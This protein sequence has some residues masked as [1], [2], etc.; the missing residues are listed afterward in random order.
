MQGQHL[1][2]SAPQSKPFDVVTLLC[3]VPMTEDVMREIGF[4]VPNRGLFC[5]CSPSLPLPEI[6]R[7]SQ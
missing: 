5:L 6:D 2:H 3:R 4:C 7:E 1:D